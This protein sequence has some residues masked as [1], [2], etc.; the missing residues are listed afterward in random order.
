MFYSL[1][2]INFVVINADVIEYFSMNDK[3][4]I[5]FMGCPEFAADILCNLHKDP[6][7]DIVAIYTRPPAINRRGN[8]EYHHPVGYTALDKLKIPKEHVH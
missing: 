3:I 1:I 6:K 2:S 8:K 4:K 7:I 5:I